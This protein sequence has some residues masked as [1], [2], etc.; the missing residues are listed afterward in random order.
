MYVFVVHIITCNIKG[1][2]YTV[3][4]AYNTIDFVK[5]IKMIL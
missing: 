5:F 4:P 2:E 3:V 1:Q